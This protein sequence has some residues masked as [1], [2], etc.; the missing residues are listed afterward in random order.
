MSAARK[1]PRKSWRDV[2]EIHPAADVFPL[3][4][5]AELRE[6]AQSIR[7]A[8]LQHKV[9][10]W[11]QL[12]NDGPKKLLL[13]GRNRLDAMESAGIPVVSED[14]FLMKH[15]YTEASSM[16]SMTAASLVIGRNIH[17]RHLTKEQRVKL[18]AEAAVADKEF[19]TELRKVVPIK[20]EAELTKKEMCSKGPVAEL[21]EAAG[22]SLPTARKALNEARAK[23]GQPSPANSR[24]EAV[25]KLTNE[26]KTIRAIAEDLGISTTTV[27]SDQ[28]A[29]GV[30]PAGKRGAPRGPRQPKTPPP[31]AV[32]VAA[33]ELLVELKRAKGSSITP[34]LLETL[35]A[36]ERE[37]RRLTTERSK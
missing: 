17:R 16:S 14:G 36:I 26:G 10:V 13:D 8:T 19:L 15:H 2:I 1:A 28:A 22:V 21:A 29:T 3:M 11:E 18:L 27:A 25:C 4:S 12:T 37:Y 20:P 32:N 7:T 35:E 6:L 24:R 9:L 31:P 34:Q 33:A 30:K 23:A 5:P